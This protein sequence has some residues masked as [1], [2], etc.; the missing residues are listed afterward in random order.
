MADRWSDEREHEWRERN[1]RRAAED[2]GR[3]DEA[4]DF[5]GQDRE[6]RS[7][8]TGADYGDY[9]SG[10][11]ADNHGRGDPSSAGY[12]ASRYGRPN[13]RVTD[14]YYETQRDPVYR[15]GYMSGGGTD[16]GP[17]QG[18][19]GV[20]AAGDRSGRYSSFGF[21]HDFRGDSHGS[22]RNYGGYATGLDPR[23]DGRHERS[24][25]GGRRGFFDRAADHVA[26]WFGA[27]QEGDRD[28]AMSHRGRGPKGYRRSDARISDD[29]H[30]RLTD[31]PWLDASEITVAVANGEVTLSG[32]VAD[33]EAKHRAERSVEHVSGVDHVQN[34]LRIGQ[35]QSS[36]PFESGN[37]LTTPGRGFGDSVLDAQA[38]GET[39][40]TD[41][42]HDH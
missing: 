39:P 40:A 12:G 8:P 42:K 17:D 38:R 6:D 3:R 23:R 16:Y 28:Q 27:G 13:E 31:D 5:R 37:P 33:R 9:G 41:H 1:A 7:W 14:R 25:Q 26:S 30:D 35:L 10:A 4:G 19:Y 2:F 24:D 22:Q 29:I 15:D 36:K 11:F 34:N 20:P 18:G 21:G 32:T